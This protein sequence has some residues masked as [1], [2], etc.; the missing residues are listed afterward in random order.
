MTDAVH[1]YLQALL[2]TR[3]GSEILA[4]AALAD[5]GEAYQPPGEDDGH[6]GEV[7]HTRPQNAG[8]RLLHAALDAGQPVSLGF[9]DL[10]GETLIHCGIAPRFE[11]AAQRFTLA[12]DGSFWLGH[13]RR[14]NRMGRAARAELADVCRACVVRAPSDPRHLLDHLLGWLDAHHYL[15]EAAGQEPGSGLPARCEDVRVGVRWQPTL[16]RFQSMPTELVRTGALGGVRR[17]SAALAAVLG[18]ATE[19]TERGD[20]P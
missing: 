14:I 15:M 16:H 6:F 17:P 10:G 20:T 1:R 7:R 8:Y 2:H 11:P 4:R 12:F 9:G 19:S 18:C 5:L 13:A 3:T